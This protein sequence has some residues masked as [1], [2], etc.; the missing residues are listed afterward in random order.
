MHIK[1]FY[2]TLM[3]PLDD[4]M[5]DINDFSNQYDV[6]VCTAGGFVMDRIK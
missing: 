2:L 5:L 6:I 3:N 4:L 1:I